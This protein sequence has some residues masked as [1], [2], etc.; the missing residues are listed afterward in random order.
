MAEDLTLRIG[1]ESEQLKQELAKAQAKITELK[2]TIV[3]LQAD[4]NSLKSGGVKSVGDEAAKAKEQITALKLELQQ[5]R[6]EIEKNKIAYK[7]AKD[8]EMQALRQ[9]REEEKLAAQEAKALAKQEAEAKKRADQ[10]AAN[11]SRLLRE[12]EKKEKAEAT[13]LAAYQAKLEKELIAREKQRLAEIAKAEKSEQSQLNQT[14]LAQASVTNK[15]QMAMMNFGYALQDASMFAVSFRGGLNAIGNNLPVMIQ[16]FAQARDEAKATGTSLKEGLVGALK[17]TGGLLIAVNL[18]VLAMQVLPKIFES[19]GKA[20]KTAKDSIKEMTDALKMKNLASDKTVISTLAEGV[21]FNELTKE[22]KATTAGTKERQVAVDKMQAAY[23]EYI[24]NIDLNKASEKDLTKWINETTGAIY[25][26]IAATLLETLMQKQSE[27]FVEAMLNVRAKKE[28]IKEYKKKG[29]YDDPARTPMFVGGS[30]FGNLADT[31][32]S[33][34]GLSIGQTAELELKKSESNLKEVTKVWGT[35]MKEM[36]SIVTDLMITAGLDIGK[37]KKPVKPV[38]PEKPTGGSKGGKDKED[39]YTEE[40]K[41]NNLYRERMAYA[42]DNLT[43]AVLELKLKQQLYE[44][45]QKENRSI[46]E[47]TG[48]RIDMIEKLAEYQR[49]EQRATLIDM[50]EKL[51]NYLRLEQPATLPG[52]VRGID[53]LVG[54]QLQTTDAKAGKKAFNPLGY[55]QSFLQE[56]QMFLETYVNLTGSLEEGFK[57]AGEAFA[58]AMAKG[59]NIFP[60]VN[61]LLEIFI[62]NLAR[63]TLQ[64]MSLALIQQVLGFIGG[65]IPFLSFLNPA[66]IPVGGAKGGGGNLPRVSNIQRPTV[67][68]PETRIRR[69]DIYLSYKSES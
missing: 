9:K 11:A 7:A 49:L 28:Q 19:T 6:L 33:V 3:K 40:E 47:Q 36:Y 38:K 32:G 51:T 16:L 50:I 23:P 22:I 48:Y 64:A 31:T 57:S 39:I 29:V 14:L 56:T 1:L 26:K 35:T 67:I 27:S 34:L 5:Q 46:E 62:D 58:G 44:L 52:W 55:D 4:L 54:G 17:G 68:I 65:D 37:A 21:A 61:S 12:Q 30:V 66:V 13:Q 8:E 63:A 60:Q 18:V 41:L 2:A 59:L 20:A 10:E 25:D 53:F 43:K 15:S 45:A 24:K 42:D 69:G